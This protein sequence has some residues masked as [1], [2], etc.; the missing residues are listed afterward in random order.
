MPSVN[1]A[2]RV[3]SV[4]Y[5]RGTYEVTYYDR[6]RSV[7][8]QINAMS[9]GEYKMP[10]VGQVV[11][12][13]H[14]S[15]GTA[16]GLTTGTVWN[17]TNKPAEGFKGLYRKEYASLKGQ[18]YERYDE[19]TG[20]YTQYVDV[21]TRRICNGEVYDE[22]KGPA[23]FIGKMQV[24][25]VSRE[26]SASMQG[27]TG[28]GLVSEEG[29]DGEAGTVINFSAGESISTESQDDTTF[30]VANINRIK[31]GKNGI[32][33]CTANSKIILETPATAAKAVIE[34]D[35]AGTVKVT[36]DQ[37]ITLQAP[38]TLV[39]GN[40]TVEGSLKAGNTTVA[41][42]L[43]AGDTTVGNLT[44]EGTLTGG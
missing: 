16:A 44:V 27:K 19:N 1:R 3:S 35:K 9:N 31:I 20:E 21:K 41:G 25:V 24:Q 40:L 6:G 37:M 30:T 43:K 13:S 4:D 18:A 10:N 11:N 33:T 26:A 36:A 34:L 8:R 29:I 7:T 12:V 28:V 32:I 2:G 38:E 5:V 23:S 22:A 15:N 42:T 17:D 39:K 14:Q